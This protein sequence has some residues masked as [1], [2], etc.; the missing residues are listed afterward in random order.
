MPVC[1]GIGLRSLRHRDFAVYWTGGLLSN[2][3]TWLQ[4]VAAS[5]YMYTLTESALMVGVLN[6]A[7][8]LPILIFSIPGGLVSD[9]VSRQ[10][11]V[12]VT[13]A[14]SMIA[15]ATLT[16]L[17]IV[18]LATPL[19]LIVVSLFVNASYA[20]AKPAL[21]AMLPSLVPKEEL[22]EA[23]ATNTLQFVAGQIAGPVLATAT[24][25]FGGVAL[26]FG[27]NA[28]TFA[29]PIAAMLLI[30]PQ[31]APARG[32]GS[33]GIA[34]GVHFLN[35]H[36]SMV[37]V[38]GSV[39]CIAALPEA[40]RTLSPAFVLGEL[41]LASNVTGL[42]I[43]SQGAGSAFG[44]LCLT[45]WRV[46]GK[47]EQIAGFGVFL[48]ALGLVSFAVAA[49]LAIALVAVWLVGVGY[50]IAFA[51]TS[52]RLQLDAPDEYRG[53]VMALHTVGHLGTRPITALA[54]GG[55]ASLGG[56]R[57]ALLMFFTLVPVAAA[58]LLAAY[59]R[60]FEGDPAPAGH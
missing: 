52:V 42:V 36:R 25:A 30:S 39:A 58:L 4:M 38:L 1:G 24:L 54:A 10:R 28:M 18:G 19:V 56:V 27:L 13:H 45:R 51:T 11:L 50:S 23:T 6:F 20:F 32:G 47:L 17:A 46:D 15:T 37:Y 53:R 40:I 59:R 14:A 60:R 8:S 12:I 44:L 3:G 5:I 29:G 31:P 41:G 21:V 26:A 48:Q 7:A 22:L 55:V 57:L 9:R 34:A 33:G 35:S 2:I 43:A 49:D 16:V